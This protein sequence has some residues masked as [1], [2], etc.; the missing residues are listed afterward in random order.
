[1]SLKGLIGKIKGDEHSLN[2][3]IKKGKPRITL[4]NKIRRGIIKITIIASLLGGM[5]SNLDAKDIKDEMTAMETIVYYM[6]DKNFNKNLTEEQLAVISAESISKLAGKIIIQTQ[7][8]I[9]QGDFYRARKQLD[10]LIKV[11]YNI[12]DNDLLK[13]LN[14]LS[15]DLK[16]L[17]KQLPTKE[18]NQIEH[19]KVERGDTVVSIQ[20]MKEKKY[21]TVTG[22]S[23]DFGMCKLI[24]EEEYT[25][26]VS[27]FFRVKN[28]RYSKDEKRGNNYIITIY[29]EME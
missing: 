17:I 16:N 18:V 13:E 9:S 28:T 14:K 10:H 27:N 23:P 1:M 2:K 3:H 11:S 22:C 15:K 25:Y 20:I 12:K 4:K 19:N 24:A 7:I 5:A 29:S 8:L 6:K 21:L 26:I